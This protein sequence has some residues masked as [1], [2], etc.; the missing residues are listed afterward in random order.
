MKSGMS[1]FRVLCIHGSTHPDSKLAALL[2]LA[3]NAARAQGAIVDH[4]NLSTQVLPIM[5]VGCA[6]QKEL[7]SVIACRESAARAD[8]F[9]I[10]TP[11]YHGAMSGALKNWF[12]F[13]Y[14][15]FAGKMAAAL[16]TTGAGNGDLPL[17]SIMTSIAWCHGFALPFR[18][19]AR[20][21]D[22]DEQGTIQTERV[23]DRATRI[24]SD[25]VRYGR[26]VR[27]P[28]KEAQAGADPLAQGFAGFHRS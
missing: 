12:D 26:A 22:F 15:E 21:A 5:K 3:V 7:E 14:S 19:A 18:V 20:S 28:F 23:R 27:T 6:E 17:T 4:F 16:C 13:L 2:E 8:A 9:L 11:E 24:G 1:E 25:L 10:G